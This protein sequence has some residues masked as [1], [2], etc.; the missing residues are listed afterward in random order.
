MVAMFNRNLE[1][2][3]YII[4]AGVDVNQTYFGF[5]LLYG[6][7]WEGDNNLVEMLIRAGAEID[8]K[9]TGEDLEKAGITP[10]IAAASRGIKE[11]V[12]QLLEAGA[13]PNIVDGKGKNASDYSREKGHSDIVKLL[14]SATP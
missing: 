11:V 10:L 6:A 1:A 12:V 9:Y 3:S 13:D 8:Y 2:S 5:S 7:A 14:T 4:E